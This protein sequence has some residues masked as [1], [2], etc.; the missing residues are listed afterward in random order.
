V[1][2]QQMSARL[3][4]QSSF[5]DAVR[6]ILEDS[7][8]LHGAEYGNVQL[9]AGDCLVIVLQRGFKAAFLE[10][11]REVRAED[12]SSCGRA[13]RTGSPI[14]VHDTSRDPEYLPYRAAARAARY[15]SVITVPLITSAHVLIGAVSNHFVNVHGP[16]KIEMETL[17]SY[18]TV[19]A[20]H[21]YELLDDAP[22]KDMALSMNRR[23]YA[24]AGLEAS[25]VE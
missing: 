10:Y 14:L 21:L 8:A 20:E 25:S 4:A 13:L 6:V 23:L 11:F 18:S 7:I 22:L 1:L 12:G 24:E 2:L 5:E 3:L 9:L 19:A 17:K 15:K 16:T